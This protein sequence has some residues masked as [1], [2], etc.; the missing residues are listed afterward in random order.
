MDRGCPAWWLFA[1]FAQMGIAFCVRLD[2]CG[3]ARTEAATFL[4]SGKSE[5][6]IE[7]RL[8]SKA[9]AQ[10]IAAIGLRTQG[11]T[12]QV[13]L[14]RVVLPDRRIE[15]LATSL[16][17]MLVCPAHTFAAIYGSRWKIEEAFETIKQRLHLEG[18][19]GELPCAI[20]QE[21]HVKRKLSR[22]RS[23][24]SRRLWLRMRTRNCPT[25]RPPPTQSIKPW[26]SNAGL[27]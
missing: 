18:V 10:L 20:E 11:L 24:S 15:V 26:R 13:R 17:D 7:R 6:I 5:L 4:H 8:P 22:V 19:S 21:I 23:P 9:V 27:H 1:L 12:V 2:G 25:Q 3:C 14:R 16:R